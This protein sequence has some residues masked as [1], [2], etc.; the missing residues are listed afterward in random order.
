MKLDTVGTEYENQVIYEFADWILK[1][2]GDGEVGDVLNDKENEIIILGD[3]LIDNVVNLIKSIVESAYP[4]LID[5]FG[6]H[7]Y[8]RNRAI[9]ASPTWKMAS[10]DWESGREQTFLLGNI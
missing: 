3:I 7:D 10:K 1:I 9:L 5:N 4:L 8:I 6:N 2:N